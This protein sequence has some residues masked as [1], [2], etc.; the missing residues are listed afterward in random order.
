L[1]S[2]KVQEIRFISALP[3]ERI[4]SSW[5]QMQSKEI[6]YRDYY[7]ALSQEGQLLW[8]FQ[9]RLNSKYYL[10]GYFD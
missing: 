9:D 1:D 3:S 8:I 6:K 4:E 7:F 10:H 5:W 2:K